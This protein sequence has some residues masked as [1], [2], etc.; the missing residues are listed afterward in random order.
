MHARQVRASPSAVRAEPL[1]AA[2]D[3]LFRQAGQ[4]FLAIKARTIVRPTMDFL[5]CAA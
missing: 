2:A 5:T 4:V 1:N 3:N